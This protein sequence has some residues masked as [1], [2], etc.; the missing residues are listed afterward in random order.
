[1]RGTDDVPTLRTEP[2]DQSEIKDFL[3]FTSPVKHNGCRVSRTISLCF[4]IFLDG[5]M[6]LAYRC[7]REE[8][9]AENRARKTSS[10]GMGSACPLNKIRERAARDNRSMG[11]L[12]ARCLTREMEEGEG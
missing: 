2:L 3:A 8:E 5:T 9:T 4:T 12:I 11:A 1:M 10:C 6:F 7:A